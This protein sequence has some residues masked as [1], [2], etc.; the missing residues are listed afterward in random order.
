MLK[1]MFMEF[2]IDRRNTAAWL[3]APLSILAQVESEESP[4][5]NNHL[6]GRPQK[7]TA[8]C[9]QPSVAIEMHPRCDEN[10]S[11]RLADTVLVARNGDVKADR[12]VLE[13]ADIDVARR[14]ATLTAGVK[15]A[16]D[17]LAV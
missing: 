6:S 5:H 14:S 16:N 3:I 10:R 2:R 11:S 9:R 13:P 1:G 7:D 12:S 17:R 4:D 8:A 15:H